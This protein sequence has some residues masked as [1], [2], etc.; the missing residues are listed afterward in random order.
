M[1]SLK[2]EETEKKYQSLWPVGAGIGVLLATFFLFIVG[3]VTVHAPLG[4]YSIE[5]VKSEG[6]IMSVGKVLYTSYLLP[7][8]IASLILLVAIIG[9]V[10]LAKKRLE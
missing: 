9:A 2:K 3:K 8:E 7:F 6:H 5:A 10:V 4:E 1:N